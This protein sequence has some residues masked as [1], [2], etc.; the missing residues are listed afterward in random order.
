MSKTNP[1]NTFLVKVI[2]RPEADDSK[3]LVRIRQLL[4][5]GLATDAHV[6]DDWVFAVR[7]Y[8]SSMFLA[9][10]KDA[11]SLMNR[12]EPAATEFDFSIAGL[13]EYDRNEVVTEFNYCAQ[14]TFDEA[15]RNKKMAMTSDS[16]LTEIHSVLDPGSADPQKLILLLSSSDHFD[17]QK[18]LE[19]SFGIDFADVQKIS[20]I[21]AFLKNVGTSQVI[22]DPSL[23]ALPAIAENQN[24]F[25]HNED[26]V[27]AYYASTDSSDTNLNTLILNRKEAVVNGKDAVNA[28]VHFWKTMGGAFNFELM[29]GETFPKPVF[30]SEP[31]NAPIPTQI[32]T[33]GD[34]SLLAFNLSSRDTFHFVTELD[35]WLNDLLNSTKYDAPWPEDLYTGDYAAAYNYFLSELEKI[36]ITAK[37]KDGTIAPSFIEEIN[38]P[39]DQSF[40]EKV[41]NEVKG[42]L[43]DECTFFTEYSS[44]WFGGNGYFHAITM[45]TSAISQNDLT[46]V[47][48]LMQIPP[49]KSLLMIILDA[50][51]GDLTYFIGAIPG[52]G[53][54]LAAIVNLA[55]STAKLAMK[56][57]EPTSPIQVAIAN[58][59]DELNKYLAL[60]IGATATHWAT[61]NGN[62]GKLKEFSLGVINE[63]IKPEMFGME[64]GAK[65]P[66]AP[67]LF[68]EAIAKS[69]RVV[70]YKGLFPGHYDTKALIGFSGSEPKPRFDRK[71]KKYDYSYYLRCDYYDSSMHLHTN[72][73]MELSYHNPAP[74]QVMED[75]FSEGNLNLNP[76]EFYMGYNGWKGALPR[77]GVG[78]ILHNPIVKVY[79]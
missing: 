54:I 64:S 68:I 2:N 41:F 14:V 13:T 65:D 38:Y 12:L 55:W 40:S 56:P 17:A 16:G 66:K 21:A 11:E 25:I 22:P 20:S 10:A 6:I 51:F 5:E 45:E 79:L 26:S 37:P 32:R 63:K 24:S 44:K 39:G 35:T 61:I 18:F 33:V 52:V 78:N 7:H 77:I 70:C 74:Q 71:N 59:A 27:S 1:T 76:I 34:N 9:E 57:G 75:L 15:K 47:A 23:S 49:T 42:H 28:N 29:W 4:N 31:T 60:M 58:M 30:R 50:I 3:K 43:T 67:E 48:N 36:G 73:Y 46:A 8:Y 69:W 62:W 72:S 53:P 19:N